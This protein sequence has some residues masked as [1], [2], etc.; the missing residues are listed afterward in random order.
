VKKLTDGNGA[1]I[2]VDTT[3]AMKL[4]EAALDFTASR[5][6]F[7]LLGV[8]PVD[9]SLNTH[10]ITFMQARKLLNFTDTDTDVLS[11]RKDSAR[12]Y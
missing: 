4:I 6:Q 10:L 11:D 12:K 8:P 5:G 2:V 1:S 9:G 7:I 3:G